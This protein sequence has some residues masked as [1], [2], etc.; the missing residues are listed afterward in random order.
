MIVYAYWHVALQWWLHVKGEIHFDCA[1]LPLSYYISLKGNAASFWSPPESKARD[2]A[3]SQSSNFCEKS[4]VNHRRV[5]VHMLPTC[6]S[7]WQQTNNPRFKI[8]PESSSKKFV[9]GW[10]WYR[11]V[12]LVIVRAWPNGVHSDGIWHLNPVFIP[13]MMFHIESGLWSL[14]GIAG[15]QCWSSC[16]TLYW[17]GMRSREWLCSLKSGSN[18]NKFLFYEQLH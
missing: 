16:C 11:M 12:G 8:G 10:S 17:W 15:T 4:W 5:G 18:G 6:P 2:P 13:K 14:A 9:T 1:V 7:R 3:A